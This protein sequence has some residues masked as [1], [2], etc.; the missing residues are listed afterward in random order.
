[1]IVSKEKAEK[2]VT[3]H[4]ACDC[5]E[6]KFHKAITTL[7]LVRDWAEFMRDECSNC[8]DIYN[9]TRVILDEIRELV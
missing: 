1:M 4:W 7:K 3:H 8:E 9:E 5:R 2:C 6:Y